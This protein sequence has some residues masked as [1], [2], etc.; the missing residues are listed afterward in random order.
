L[1]KIICIFEEYS[2]KKNREQNV[3]RIE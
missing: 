3:N 2:T 1:A